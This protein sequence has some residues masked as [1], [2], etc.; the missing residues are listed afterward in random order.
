MNLGWASVRLKCRCGEDVQT[1]LRGESV[2]LETLTG[3]RI[4]DLGAEC[5][6]C[7]DDPGRRDGTLVGGG[8]EIP[9]AQVGG[10]QR[11]VRWRDMADRQLDE[12]RRR[13]GDPELHGSIFVATWVAMG[14]ARECEGSRY[15]ADD[16]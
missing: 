15:E 1:S 4:G 14:V 6:A 13:V 16:G 8:A 3:W 10:D 5:P 2:D 12:F 9:Q 7:Q 11:W